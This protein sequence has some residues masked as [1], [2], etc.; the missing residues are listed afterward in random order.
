M[1]YEE[2]KK[3][4]GHSIAIVSYG[5]NDNIALECEDCNEVLMDFDK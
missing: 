1:N 3:H 2:L 5:D 4:I